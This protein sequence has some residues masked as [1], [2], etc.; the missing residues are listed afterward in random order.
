MVAGLRADGFRLAVIGPFPVV[1]V[2]AASRRLWIG[3]HAAIVR[4][5]VLGQPQWAGVWRE[6]KRVE[7]EGGDADAVP[8]E[9]FRASPLPWRATTMFA[10]LP[11][12]GFDALLSS[13]V[14]E[15]NAA[16]WRVEQLPTQVDD[17]ERT[18][19]LT[20]RLVSTLDDLRQPQR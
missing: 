5:A 16:Q 3:F 9:R 14:D 11:A 7:T 8:F 15:A 6:Q 17:L 10:H 18:I 2:D 4:S 13:V 20:R 1:G 19:E 12:A